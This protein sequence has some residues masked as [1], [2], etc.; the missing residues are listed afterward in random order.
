MAK[1]TPV[2][3]EQPTF[4]YG[5]VGTDW[6]DAFSKAMTD[7]TEAQFVINRP[8]PRSIADEDDTNYDEDKVQAFYDKRDA[9][10][11]VIKDSPTVQKNLMAQV[12]VDVPRGWLL[13]DAPEDIDWS[14]PDNLK[15]VSYDGY[16]KLLSVWIQ[17]GGA[18]AKAK[19]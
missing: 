18:R 2:A 9:A 12:L 19:N 13:D 1:K 16:S 4:D 11:A 5:R 10:L 6:R 17:G 8:L 7:V 3:T 15:Y 14:K